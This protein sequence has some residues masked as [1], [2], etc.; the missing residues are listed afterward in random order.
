MLGSQSGNPSL[1]VFIVLFCSLL[2]FYAMVAPTRRVE[3]RR[4]PRERLTN[5]VEVSWEDVGGPRQCSRGRCL[6]S[7]TGGLGMELQDHIEVAARI[8]FIIV[9]TSV[10]GT[11][12]VRYCR[13]K[14]SKYVV[15]AEFTSLC[16]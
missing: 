2:V 16:W 9:H 13:P 3:R 15:G 6:N 14:G 1:A 8:Q 11:A 5:P 12:Q 10:A 4:D 7:S